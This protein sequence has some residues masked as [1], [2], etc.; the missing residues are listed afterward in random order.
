M[1]H[2]DQHSLSLYRPSSKLLTLVFSALQDFDRHEVKPSL[3][4]LS[5]F[6]LSQSKLKVERPGMPGQPGA[7]VCR[8]S[9]FVMLGPATDAPHF[10]VEFLCRPRRSS[11]PPTCSHGG[12]QESLRSQL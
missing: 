6:L 3:Q 1:E 10:E 8:W 4:P 12:T 5:Y 2:L 11:F 7:K 9:A